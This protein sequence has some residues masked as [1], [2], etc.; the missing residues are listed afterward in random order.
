MKYIFALTLL[1]SVTANAQ[2]PEVISIAD[3]ERAFA[4]KS[5]E[6][7]TRA[8]FL[9]NF[10]G[11]TIAFNNGE[12]VPG[13]AGWEQRPEGNGYLFWWPVF[14]DVAASGDWGYTTGPAVLGPDKETKEVK[15]GLY[16]SSVWRKDA[17]GNWKVLIDL[18]SATYDEAEKLT[19]LKTSS[20]TP[21]R[22]AGDHT[23]AT[24]ELLAFEKAY[25]GELNQ[26]QRS[27]IP[28]RFAPEARIHRPRE[29]PN[30]NPTG[31]SNEDA[32]R[33]FTFE[34]VGGEVAPSNDMAFTYGRVKVSVT[35]DGKSAVIPVGYLHVWKRHGSE[36]KLVLDV[37]GS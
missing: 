4:R 14:A 23:T 13:R 1:V 28:S 3:A 10:T 2:R 17:S 18:G 11:K 20:G 7:S 21:A 35:R 37:I 9:E 26:L 36:W 31:S 8:A 30:L 25:L 24:N 27:F 5:V 22:I 16:Y 33:K 6:V 12:P 15:G 19:E 34:N 29:K 32:A